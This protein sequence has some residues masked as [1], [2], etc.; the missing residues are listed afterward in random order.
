[1]LSVG[2]VIGARFPT[3]ALNIVAGLAFKLG[4]RQGDAAEMVYLELVDSVAKHFYPGWFA[5]AS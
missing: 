1:M 4:A 3:G 5:Q 2:A